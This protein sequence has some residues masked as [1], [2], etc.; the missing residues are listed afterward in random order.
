LQ[1]VEILE[2]GE[3]DPK[4][5]ALVTGNELTMFAA[6]P[7]Y[8]KFAGS[9]PVTIPTLLLTN[10][11]LLICKDRLFRPR[12]DFSVDWSDVDT[13]EGEPWMGGGPSIQL[14]VRNLDGSVAVE[15]I[16]DPVEA[17]AIETAIRSGY[18]N[19]RDTL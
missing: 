18:M 16:A 14:L 2:G 17:L 9:K 4:I 6:R 12:I 5:A 19:A 1:L 8:A 15:L 7:K 13:V 3:L 10:R 11:R